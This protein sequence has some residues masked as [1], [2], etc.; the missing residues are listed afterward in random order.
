VLVVGAQRC[1]T[2]S[3][4]KYLGAHPECGASIRKEARFFT[5]Y[6]H[7]GTDWYRAH[8]PLSA[9]RPRR[10]IYF[11]ATPDYLLDPRVPQRAK[12]LLPEDFRIIALLR[13]PVERAY[14]HYWHNRR[15]GSER[16]PF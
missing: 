14:S 1:G 7:E 10:Q 6:Y 3:L 16:I 12:A 2:S 15:L 11:E 5:E 4:F 9:G 8:F 13:D